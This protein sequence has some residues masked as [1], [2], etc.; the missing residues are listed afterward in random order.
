MIQGKFDKLNFIMQMTLVK[1][2]KGQVTDRQ[3]YLPSTYSTRDW[4]LKHIK[5]S[6][7]QQSQNNE[8]KYV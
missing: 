4:Y 6:Q 3:K 1:K 2:R 5:N 7:N 8:G